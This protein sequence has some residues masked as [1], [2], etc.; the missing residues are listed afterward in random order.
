MMIE[1]AESA[2]LANHGDQL[3]DF[4]EAR[5]IFL[6]NAGVIVWQITTMVFH[7]RGLAT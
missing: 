7:S 3:N 2:Q 4:M 6:P 5:E 1:W